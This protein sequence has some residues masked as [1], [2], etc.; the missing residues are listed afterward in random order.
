MVAGA[1]LRCCLFS[2][3]AI[4]HFASQTL[5]CI[6]RNS[7]AHA[8]W[9]AA[10]CA[11]AGRRRQSLHTAPPHPVRMLCTRQ[12]MSD[13][14]THSWRRVAS[15][16]ELSVSLQRQPR[17]KHQ[18]HQQHP[19]RWRLQLLPPGPRPMKRRPCLRTRPGRGTRSLPVQ[20]S[21]R[22]R[23][24]PPPVP[25]LRVPPLLPAVP[26]W[27]PASGPRPPAPGPGT[28]G[29]RLLQPQ[30]LQPRG[31][32]TSPTRERLADWARGQTGS[33]LAGRHP[34]NKLVYVL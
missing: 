23:V 8:C 14:L 29:P 28:S 7:C 31:L 33:Q 20:S 15:T 4:E 27:R 16:S 12:A 21:S 26:S 11:T 25:S 32:Q 13:E 2:T 24:Q 9:P 34:P 17:P 18:Q 6:P 30:P 5:S 1:V 19:A 3:F 10:S 22:P